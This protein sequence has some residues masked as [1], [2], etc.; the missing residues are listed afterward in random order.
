MSPGPSTFRPSIPQDELAT[1]LDEH[2]LD[3]TLV[4]TLDGRMVGVVRREDLDS[5]PA[6]A[7]W[8]QVAVPTWITAARWERR[9]PTDWR[10][11]SP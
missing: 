2:D 9:Q 3:H 11:S 6:S 4:T 5:R 1:Y 8:L 7:I 10:G